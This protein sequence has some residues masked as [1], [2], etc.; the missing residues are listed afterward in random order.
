M[1]RNPTI[2]ALAAACVL[3]SGCSTR[4]RNFTAELSAPV[5][6]RMAFENDFRTCQ[7]LVRQGHRNGFRSAATGLAVGSGAVGA[8]L[9][10]GSMTAGGVYSSYG[11]AGAAA[12][13]A[14]MA[15]TAVVGIAGFG[16]TRLIRGGKERKFKRAMDACLTEYGYSVGSW[17]KVHK[18][19][20]AAKIAAGSAI[21]LPSAPDSA[22]GVSEEA[23]AAPE[24]TL[25]VASQSDPD[26]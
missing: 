14:L 8:G 19:D 5:P 15:T 1:N 11:A 2:F 17:A 13:A 7:T 10:V 3:V 18:K 12:G 23:L 24:T 21:V 25:I 4:P 6:D 16:L 22:T 20:D 9:A 26:S